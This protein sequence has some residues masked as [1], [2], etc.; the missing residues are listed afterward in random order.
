LQ[1]GHSNELVHR[2]GPFAGHG[3]EKAGFYSDESEPRGHRSRHIA[4]YFVGER[5]Y[6]FLLHSLVLLKNR[7]VPL[8]QFAI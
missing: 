3:S 2:Q 1:L 6:P 5:L 4:E 7:P 8:Q